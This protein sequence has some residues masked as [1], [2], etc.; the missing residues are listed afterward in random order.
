MQLNLLAGGG[1]CCQWGDNC[2][3]VYQNDDTGDY[4]VQGRRL[5][6]ATRTN[7]AIPAHE[8]AVEVPRSVIEELLR[9]LAGS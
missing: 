3:A 5:D 1:P 9:R 8:D 6:D 2:P 7:L 4:I